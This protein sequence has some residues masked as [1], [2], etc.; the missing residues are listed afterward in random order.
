MHCVAPALAISKQMELTNTNNKKQK[1]RDTMKRLLSII[2]VLMLLFVGC[3]KDMNI[4]SPQNNQ[5]TEEF[6]TRTSPEGLNVNAQY[7]VSKVIDGS[8][9]GMIYYGDLMQAQSGNT[10]Q[11][12]AA[13]Y[14][15]AGAF[16][17]TKTITMTLDTKTCTGTFSPSM[18]FNKPVSFSALFTGVNL[19]GYSQSQYTFVYYDKSGKK[20]VIGSSYLYFDPVKG[21]LGILNAQLPHF[22]RYGFVRNSL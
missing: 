9:G 22:S 7:T 18:T 3:S 10:Q 2:A 12:Y 14:F 6:V 20:Y 1:K 11:V 8:K 21:V 16:S 5:V 19:S 4:N 13:C 17:G 15:P